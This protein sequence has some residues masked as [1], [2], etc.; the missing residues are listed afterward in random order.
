MPSLI[1]IGAPYFLGKQIERRTEVSDLEQSG[2]AAEI[3]AE[4]VNIVPDYAHN[5]DPITA[6][7]R[8][9]A[10]TIAAHRD[11]FPIIFTSDCTNAI[12]AVGGLN[13]DDLGVI[14]FDAHGDFNTPET[15][16]SGFLGGM[17]LAMLAGRGVQTYME[18]VGLG[19]ISETNMILT[20]ARDLDPLEAE[21]LRNSAVTHLPDIRALLTAPLPDKP[22]YMHI[23]TDIVNPKDMPG[24]TYT[25]PG[26]PSL[27]LVAD[28]VRRI[29]RDGNVAGA[30]FSLWN[31]ALA[32]DKLPL[33]GTLTLA[34]ALVAGL[35]EHKIHRM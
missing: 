19:P 24:M 28:V 13:R 30:L 23:D 18:Q 3:G 11:S 15:S 22:L 32:A 35:R 27:S 31:G 26:G 7:N 21:A 29:A 5:A 6:V 10:E 17:P 9:L 2:F 33:E 14:W 16:P 12:G 34:R 25:A 20:D 1:C 8:A 4:W